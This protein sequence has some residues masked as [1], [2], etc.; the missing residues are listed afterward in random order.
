MAYL[1]KDTIVR[2]TGP[3]RE[4]RSWPRPGEVGVV[5]GGDGGA[6]FVAWE[7]TQGS[8]A[9]PKAWLTRVAEILP[10]PA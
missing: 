2:F 7:H 10:E 1:E 3:P 9:W 8:V 6:V 4:G 5:T